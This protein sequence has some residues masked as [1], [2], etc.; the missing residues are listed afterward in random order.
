MI[1]VKSLTKTFG[2]HIAVNKISFDIPMGQV[3]GILGPNGAGKSTTMR[4]L[5]GFLEPDVNSTESSDIQIDG[6]S[7][8]DNALVCKKQIGYLP[9]STPLYADAHVLDAIKDSGYLHGM[10]LTEIENRLPLVIK[11]CQLQDV[12]TKKISELSKGYKQRVGLAQALIH[13]PK[14]LILDEPTAGLDPNQINEI[15]QLIK[16]ISATKTIL[17]ST[18]I[19][20]EVSAMCHRIILINKGKIAYDGETHALQT[21][22]HQPLIFN[23]KVKG[24]W[25]NIITALENLPSFISLQRLQTVTQSSNETLEHTFTVH[26]KNEPNASEHLFDALVLAQSKILHMTST[27]KTLEEIFSELTAS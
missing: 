18:H 24:Q 9:E 1:S 7:L 4:M 17:I 10:S 21:Q 12:L 27:T 19:L 26:I 3:V 11:Q 15:R 13:D 22:G 20:S 16:S 6:L 23:M 2:N 5:T 14:I 8:K 25:Q